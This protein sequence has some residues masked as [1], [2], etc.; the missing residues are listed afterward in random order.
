MRSLNLFLLGPPEVRLDTTPLVFA[1]RKTL[2]LLAYL[3]LEQG[4]QP[5]ERLATLLWP[6]ARVERS[7]A[8][9]RNTLNHLK[10]SIRRASGQHEPPYLA[11]THETLALDSE[12]EIELD[13]QAVEQAYSLARAERSSRSTPDGSASLAT[14]QLAA[15][16]QRGDFLAGF[17]LGDAPGFDEWVGVQREAWRRRLGLILDRLSE[18]QFGRG[19]FANTAETVA[20]WLALDSLNEVAYRRKMRAHFAA[21]ERGQAL[22][23][24]ET[25]RSLLDGELNIKPEPDTELLVARIRSHRVFHPRKALKSPP[26]TPLGYLEALFEG[27]FRERQAL[28][29]R[30]ASAA[31]GQPQVV[32]VTGEAGIGKTRLAQTFLDAGRTQGGHILQSSAYESGRGLPFQPWL[33]AFRPE[34]DR[35][36]IPAEW[37][38]SA[39]Y[40]RL[41]QLVPGLP[42]RRE[43]PTYSTETSQ[44]EQTPAPQVEIYEAVAQFTL[45]LAR[46]APLVLFIDDLQWADSATLDVL[47]YVL[48]R[49]RATAAR[50]LVLVSL[51]SEALQAPGPSDQTNLASWVLE[52]EHAWPALH[53][54]LEPLS[55]PEAMHLLGSL[56]D[57]SA[58]EFTEWVFNETR[59]H[60]FYIMETLKDLL[61]RGAIHPHRH[62]RSKWLFEVDRKHDL[63]RAVQVPSTVRAVIRSRLSRL[64]PAAFALLA[65][66]TV[67]EHALTFERL[68]AVAR[69]SPDEGLPA[70]DEL[71]SGRLL[72]DVG[73][74][75]HVSSFAFANDML[76]D[77]AY[78]EAGDARRRLFHQRALGLLEAEQDPAAVLAYHALSGGAAQDALRYSLAAVQEALRIVAPGEARVHLSNARRLA[79]EA[80]LAGAEV[81]AR[82]RDLY[83]QLGQAYARNGQTEL[84]AEAFAEGLKIGV[85]PT[86]SSP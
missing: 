74:P 78:T 14:L 18:I 43:V 58:P 57:P 29:E 32:I 79:H 51:R 1:T 83:V 8:S 38:R 49:W 47:H 72:R 2:A 44:D 85:A 61:E 21:G 26:T 82:L 35:V 36:D 66:G 10:T 23:T 60:P 6:E 62:P 67:L 11:I 54:E 46:Q 50:A 75:G 53:L 30:Y 40:S 24:Y 19:E 17:S 15:A 59:G 80:A 28:N 68:C 65:A 31:E 48:R 37:R 27:R 84:A 20:H 70:L 7:F 73:R 63:G 9:L 33:E 5:R 16:C 34:L 86:D 64:S 12:A 56:L 76:R 52:I 77:V 55:R 3:A 4:P 39:W 25:C 13:L 41:V 69:L 22:Q 71:V 81:E 45:A 42:E